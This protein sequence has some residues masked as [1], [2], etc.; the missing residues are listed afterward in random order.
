MASLDLK[1]LEMTWCSKISIKGRQGTD[2][3][4]IFTSKISIN[5]QYS[6]EIRFQNEQAIVI[7]CM[8]E[9]EVSEFDCYLIFK[10][11]K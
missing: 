4:E 8:L 5:S 2:Q 3:Y 11:R 9:D 7:L 10:Q 6:N 1:I